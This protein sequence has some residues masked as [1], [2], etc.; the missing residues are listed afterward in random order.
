MSA[1]QNL[2]VQILFIK[3]AEDEET[4][5]FPVP[6]SVFEFHAQQAI[7]K[8]LKALIGAHNAIYPYTHDLQLL[9]NQLGGLG[10][11]LPDF[12]VPLPV[13]TPFGVIVRYDLGVSLTN[14]ERQKYRT[15]VAAVRTFVK[16]RVDVL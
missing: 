2:Q 8:L 6:D 5:A 3:S 9:M 15:V 14:D 4:L 10:E 11:E 13:F 16:A 7:E 12:G 1:A